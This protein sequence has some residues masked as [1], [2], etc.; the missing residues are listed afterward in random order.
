MKDYFDLWIL[1]SEGTL[2]PTDLHHAISATFERRKFAM[3][4]SLPDG[5]SDSFSGDT[6]KQKQWAAFLK[7]NRLEAMDLADVVKRLREEFQKLGIF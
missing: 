7:K 4:S 5:L 1:M 3:I 2:D 6:T